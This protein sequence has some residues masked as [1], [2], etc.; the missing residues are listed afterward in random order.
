MSHRRGAAS[1]SVMMNLCS[2]RLQFTR[3]AGHVVA[4]LADRVAI[5]NSNGERASV[6]LHA[7][8]LAAFGDQLW[9]TNA[10][11]L[12]R[13]D[14]DGRAIGGP[15][16]CAGM[17]V[18]ALAGPAAAAVSAR[19]WFGE[20]ANLATVAL[21]DD[22]L[23][24]VGGRTIEVV[25]H[26]GAR[27]VRLGSAC[28][29]LPPGSQL[30]AAAPL[31]DGSGVALF[32]RRGDRCEAWSSTIAGEIR[33]VIALPEGELR[34]AA[35]RG[36]VL[37]RSQPETFVAFDLR[38][39]RVIGQGA[40]AGDD[41]AIDP[42][43]HC[44]AAS[45][46]GELHLTTL[47]DA[48]RANHRRTAM[49]DLD[50]ADESAQQSLETAEKV[51]DVAGAD[52][53]ADA[54]GAVNGALK[55]DKGVGEIEKGDLANGVLDVGIGGTGLL[56]KVSEG[57][58][59]DAAEVVS[60]GLEIGKGVGEIATD[61]GYGGKSLDGLHDILTGG[62]G[63]IDALAPTGS[64]LQLGAKAFGLGMNIGDAIAPTIFGEKDEKGPKQEEI[65]EDGVFHA[66]TGNSAVDWVCGT[67]KYTD[68]RF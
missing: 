66:S 49:S 27:M 4:A 45:C 30:I 22:A 34:L 23:P 56:S 28:W 63:A 5:R 9:T 1:T 57:P 8:S 38:Y 6:G 54:F 25:R 55:V 19:L 12:Q 42:D 43:G 10:A 46:N 61:Q 32:V 59:K 13:W 29:R 50:G 60:S 40:I 18:P 41:F 14:L 39:G 31:F 68:G 48:L 44:L 16:D 62:A 58:L 15:I 67:G 51:L 7:T 64:P 24:F 20:R 47:D 3:D 2:P 11:G 37:V 65:P 17:L 21:A 33:H 36:L 26:R 35:R 52:T 53:G